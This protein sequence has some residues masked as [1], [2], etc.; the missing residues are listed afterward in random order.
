MENT[1]D[2]PPV[3]EVAALL[4]VADVDEF[5]V[6]ERAFAD[7]TRKGVIAALDKARARIDAERNEDARIQALYEFQ[8]AIS[9]TSADKVIVGLD[10]VG[11]G[12]LA[13]P[14]CVG[15]AVLPD[16]P[17]IAFL[18]DSKKLKPDMREK[19]AQRIKDVA[20]CYTTVFVDAEDIDSLGI[21]ASLKN[22]FSQALRQIEA[23]VDVD[24][25]LLDGNPLHFDRRE[26][27]VVKGDAKCASIAAASIIAKTERDHLMDELD[28][29]YPGYGFAS[30]KGYGTKSHRD[31]IHRLGLSP[32][33]RISYCSEFIQ[34][35]LF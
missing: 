6:L 27:N 4:A 30:N 25:V 23:K 15:A 12:P 31:A 7:D 34:N 1:K 2:I 11:R 5:E 18:N 35:T 26:I 9:R 22:A 8:R 16:D 10:E 14:L 21:I 19:V 32:I 17:R 28:R 33:H 24:A 13:G 20:I 29:I 3:S